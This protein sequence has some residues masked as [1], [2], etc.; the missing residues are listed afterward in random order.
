MAAMIQGS[1]APA[2][3][4]LCQSPAK[5][6]TPPSKEGVAWELGRCT[7]MAD[8][9][10]L[11]DTCLGVPTWQ[12]VYLLYKGPETSRSFLYVVIYKVL[13]SLIIIY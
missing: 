11:D 10:T 1:S 4:S 13:F 12:I 2:R 7:K 3:F 8:C 6:V 9:V 5:H